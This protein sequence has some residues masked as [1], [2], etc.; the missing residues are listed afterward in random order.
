MPN[1]I[2]KY[3]GFN[4]LMLIGA[5][6][7]ALGLAWNTVT[8][9][10]HNYYLQQKYNQLQAEVELQKV[11]NQNL[12]YNIAYLKTDEALEIAARDKFSLAAP[13]ETLV[14]LP[15]NGQDALAPV[16]KNAKASSAQQKKGWQAN[17]SS[18][19]Q[20]LQGNNTMKSS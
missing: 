4:D 18:W 15:K 8:A 1:K 7:I 13:G 12:K 6:L 14:Y 16:A 20:F 5:L 10:Q 19:W 3:L 17:L 11:K 2:S 9:M